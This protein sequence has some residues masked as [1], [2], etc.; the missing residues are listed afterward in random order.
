MRKPELYYAAA[1]SDLQTAGSLAI[2]VADKTLALF[3]FGERVYVVDNRSPHMGFSLHQGSIHEGILTCHWL[4][5]RFD[6]AS[7]GT[8]DQWANDVP[9]FPVEIREDEI[10]VD[11]QQTTGISKLDIR[12]ISP[13]KPLRRSI[14]WAGN[15]PARFSPVW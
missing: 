11:L 7:G 5:A 12:W 6:L 2:Q 8:F 4:H 9:S 1:M 3:L 13:T 15:M 10:W 14:W